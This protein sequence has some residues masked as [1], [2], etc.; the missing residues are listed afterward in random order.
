MSRST[1]GQS[2]GRVGDL[3]S[4]SDG[5]ARGRAASGSKNVAINGVAAPRVGDSAADGGVGGWK[6]AAGAQFVLINGKNLHRM[7]DAIGG[8]NQTAWLARGSANVFVG[9]P[10]AVI[11]KKSLA[12]PSFLDLAVA[13]IDIDCIPGMIKSFGVG[14]SYGLSRVFGEGLMT[15]GIAGG[16]KAFKGVLT[17]LFKTT[18]AWIGVAFEY[19]VLAAAMVP[20]FHSWARW[21]FHN[22]VDRLLH[23][24]HA[25]AKDACPPPRAVNHPSRW[26][27]GYFIMKNDPRWGSIPDGCD[28]SLAVARLLEAY[29]P[30]FVE[31]PDD[32]QAISFEN[33]LSHA[34]LDPLPVGATSSPKSLKDY[35]D[36]LKAFACKHKAPA[37][38]HPSTPTAKSTEDIAN[39]YE[40]RC[41]KYRCT[42]G[43]FTEATGENT[44]FLEDHPYWW[45]TGKDDAS[46]IVDED[47]ARGEKKID[48][49]QPT[50]HGRA[51]K[52]GLHLIE[53]QYF[54]IR[55]GSFLPNSIIDQ[56]FFEHGGDGEGCSIMVR[57]VNEDSPWRLSGALFDEAHSTGK[58]CNC[59]P[60]ENNLP[61]NNDNLPVETSNDGRPV[62][63]VA[64][65]SHAMS[66]SSGMRSPGAGT[67]D[68]YPTTRRISDYYLATSANER[69]RRAVFTHQITWGQGYLLFGKPYPGKDYSPAPD[70]S[71]SED[72][73]WKLPSSSQK[74]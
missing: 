43:S 69:I 64:I 8:D 19:L 36:C 49:D 52:R 61:A 6:I 13:W 18:G 1:R 63:Y 65:G 15:L 14:A 3:F 20:D 27:A 9:G 28:V 26:D 5:L 11:E 74:T 23:G 50:Y 34:T 62:I 33:L 7:G 37:S 17:A 60:D 73:L 44:T 45:K 35:V 57:R 71:I 70:P 38:F 10:A 68:F 51:I 72:V 24:W 53:L 30:V 47:Y 4:S 55:F 21:F 22:Y 29:K 40:Q 41:E 12:E 25:L 2:A 42:D 67:V 66:A 39:E 54:A 32:L 58:C 56:D 46:L 48:V 31:D 16:V 59:N